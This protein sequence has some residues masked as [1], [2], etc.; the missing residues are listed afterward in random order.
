MDF[1]FSDE[2]VAVRDLAAKIFDGMVSVERIKQVETSD[3]RMDDALWT[4]LAK[5]DLLGLA[6]P[7]TAG[8]SGLGMI[9]VCLLLQEQGRTL[10]PVPVHAGVI[11]GAL[12]LAAFGTDA[13]KDA[14][15]PGILDGSVIVTAAL[16]EPSSVDAEAPRTTATPRSGGWVLDGVKCAVPAGTVAARVLVPATAPDGS[17]TVFLVDPMSPGVRRDH[18]ETTD[19][20]RVGHLTLD[21]VVV[22]PGDVVGGEGAGRAVVGWMRDRALVGLCALQLGVAEEALRLAAA[23]TSTRLQFGKPLSTFQGVSL[24]AADAYI[25]TSAMRVTL[26]Q[27][28]WRL[29][30]DLASSKEIAVAKWWAADGGERVVHAT[31]HLHGGMGADVDYPVHRYFLW[32]KQIADTLG[33]A[34]RQLAVLGAQIAASRP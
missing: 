34:S 12:P 15:L 5:A 32:G 24:R 19:R 9:E 7:V 28:A 20:Q 21:G 18:A 11:L 16:E 26:W 33:G 10:A 14:W 23:Y 22:A 3:D 27:A 29:D 1:S 13:Q 4:E 2:Q 31:Q 17:V 25:D 6:V 30:H 8:G